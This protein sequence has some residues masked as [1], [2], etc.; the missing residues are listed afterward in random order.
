MNDSTKGKQI[1]L[2]FTEQ[3]VFS[4]NEIIGGEE[5]QLSAG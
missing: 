3:F 1:V 5:K 4:L 2:L